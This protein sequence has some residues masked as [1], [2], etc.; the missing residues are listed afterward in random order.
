MSLSVSIPCRLSF[1]TLPIDF[2]FKDKSCGPLSLLSL[3][4]V[5]DLSFSSVFG[6]KRLTTGVLSSFGPDGG[7]SNTAYVSPLI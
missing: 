4:A 7:G 6:M 3:S 5:V 1:E 2:I